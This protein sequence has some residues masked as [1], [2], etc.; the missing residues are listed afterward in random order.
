MEANGK[1]DSGDRRRQ[2]QRHEEDVLRSAHLSSFA[3]RTPKDGAALIN[4][5]LSHCLDMGVPALFVSVPEA[6][7]PAVRK[8][9]GS[10]ETTVAPATVFGALLSADAKWNVNTSEV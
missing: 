5:A 2:D 4:A 8:H 6:D 10:L 7:A 3:Y 1:H 9:L